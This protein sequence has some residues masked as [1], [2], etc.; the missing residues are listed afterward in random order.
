MCWRVGECNRGEGYDSGPEI[1]TMCP[2]LCFIRWSVYRSY[3]DF[4][5]LEILVKKLAIVEEIASEVL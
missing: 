2:R 3:T 4:G 1:Y 5:G